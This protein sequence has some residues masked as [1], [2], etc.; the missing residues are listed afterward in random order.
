M[1]E[2]WEEIIDRAEDLPSGL[3]KVALVEHAV[4]IADSS[5]S[6]NDKYRARLELIDAANYAGCPEKVLVA[7]SWCLA[8]YDAKPNDYW[9]YELMWRYKW[10]SEKLACFPQIARE[11]IEEM[12]NDMERRY[13]KLSYS[14]RPVHGGRFVN[15][16]RMGLTEE[17]ADHYSAY[18]KSRRDWMSDCEACECD[19]AVD[20]FIEKGHYKRA[21]NKAKPILNGK[22]S[23]AEVPHLTYATLLRPLVS[24]GRMDEAAEIHQKGYRKIA[25]NREFLGA[26]ARHL[27][28]LSFIENDAKAIRLIEQHL[29]IAIRANDPL[30][31]LQFYSSVYGFFASLTDRKPRAKKMMLPVEMPGFRD[32]HRYLPADLASQF[33]TEAQEMATAFDQRNDNDH[34]TRTIEQ[35]HS[36]CRNNA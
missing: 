21:I 5:G 31:K 32:D 35:T 12:H 7:F 23:C 19:V 34:V 3:E 22:L 29:P 33:L 13:K 24:L 9:P 11:K 28:Y 17:A 10:V 16:L 27:Q 15:A 1:S 26:I 36:F 14:I 8:K 25:K 30:R 6:E 20:Y 2:S 4:R 18:S